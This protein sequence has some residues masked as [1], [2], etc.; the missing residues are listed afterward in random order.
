MAWNHRP[1]LCLM[2]PPTWRMVVQFL[3]EPHP[4]PCQGSHCQT[5]KRG[6]PGFKVELA[7]VPWASPDC[8]LCDLFPHLD[9]LQE[10]VLWGQKV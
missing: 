8:S 3:F 5:Q 7:S 10:P 2:P 4:V 1:V 6:L 9:V